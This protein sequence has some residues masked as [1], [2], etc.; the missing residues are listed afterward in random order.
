MSLTIRVKVGKK[1]YI[2]LPKLVRELV[3]IKENEELILRV[4]EGRVVI[5]WAYPANVAFIVGSA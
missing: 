1:G 3:G 5:K 4:E 2:V